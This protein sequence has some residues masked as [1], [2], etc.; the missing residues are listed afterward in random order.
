MHDARSLD[1]TFLFETEV[2]DLLE[3]ALPVAEQERDDVP[4]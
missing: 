3:K 4:L 1:H 2:A